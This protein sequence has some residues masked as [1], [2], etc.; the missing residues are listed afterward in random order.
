MDKKMCNIRNIQNIR[1]DNP[2]ADPVEYEVIIQTT[3]AIFQIHNVKLYVLVVMLSINNNIKLLENIK[4]GFKRTISWNKY[5]SEIITQP[6]NNKI[7]YLIDPLYGNF[8][9][10]SFHSKL[11][12]MMLQDI[13]LMSITY[14]E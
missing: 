9:Y 6:K 10:L 7:D 3:E 13:L 4:Q 1:V 5:R 2:N 12:V 11:V 14:H 8:N